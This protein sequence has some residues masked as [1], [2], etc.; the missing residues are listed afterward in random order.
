MRFGHQIK[1]CTTLHLTYNNSLQT[2]KDGQ[3]IKKNV[4]SVFVTAELH[5]PNTF[6]EDLNKIAELESLNFKIHI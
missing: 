3:N 5:F 1:F 4:S 2:K 6:I